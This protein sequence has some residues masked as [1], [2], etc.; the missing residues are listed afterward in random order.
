MQLGT[1]KKL[2]TACEGTEARYLI[3]ALQVRGGCVGGLLYILVTA[4]YFVCRASCASTWRS[5]P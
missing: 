2:M 4:R 1:I 5:R 3:R